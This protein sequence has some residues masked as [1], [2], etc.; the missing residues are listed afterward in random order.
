MKTNSIILLA[1]LLLPI[2]NGCTNDTIVPTGT[3]VPP[4][5][6]VK[7]PTVEISAV[8]DITTITASAGGVI[9]SD[10]GSS[11]T[12]RG[13]CWSTN[14]TPKM[15]D[16][17]TIDGTGTGSFTSTING[18][19]VHTLYYVRA[20]AANSAGTAYSSELSFLTLGTGGPIIFNPT[21]TY[22]S[23]TDVDG[24][25]YKTIQIGTQTWMAENLKTTKYRNGEPI[26][27]LTAAAD[28]NASTSGAYSWYN[29]DI[30]NKATYGALYNLYAIK[31][32]RGIAP[33]GW[34][35]PTIDEAVTLENYLG[36]GFVAGGKLKETGV[37]HWVGPN[38]GAT[39][40][41]GF[42][43]LPGGIR[44]GSSFNEMEKTGYFGLFWASIYNDFYWYMP[45]DDTIFSFE[46][47]GNGFS[48]RCI[49]D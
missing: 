8:T 12:S 7:V 48:V 16:S 13:V 43:A 2:L 6:K 19:S 49:K 23:V 3:V 29:N 33:V 46:S 40:E 9:T 30:T 44:S 18:L 39:N 27:N 41:S 17:K 28:W 22:G 38:K 20:Y 37:T 15:A 10:G 42:T 14:H 11:I 34:H 36:G 5:T 21:L 35:V 4:G 31:D 32:S 47:F 25:V 1:G 24:N 26:S 45:F